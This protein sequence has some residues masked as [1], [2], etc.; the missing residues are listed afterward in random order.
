M[1]AWSCG[2]QGEGNAG[3]VL[4]EK[5]MGVR[6][7]QAAE[8]ALWLPRRGSERRRASFMLLIRIL[9]DP[10][11]SR[12]FLRLSATSGGGY[13]KRREQVRSVGASGVPPQG[14]SVLLSSCD[15]GPRAP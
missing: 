9:Q 14:T 10:G 2:L 12:T 11:K 13:P 6:R 4:P 8:T 3:I 5:V 1:A 15:F 7:L